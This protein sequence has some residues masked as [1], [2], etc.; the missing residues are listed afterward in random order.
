MRS[1]NSKSSVRVMIAGIGGASLG[2]ELCKSLKLAKRYEVFGCDISSTAYGLHDKDFSKTY[3]IGRED[4]VNNVA[5]E[6]GQEKKR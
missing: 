2:T 6:I 3:L 4:Y 5:V 1:D